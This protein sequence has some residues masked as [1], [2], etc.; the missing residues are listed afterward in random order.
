MRCARHEGHRLGPSQS[1]AAARALPSGCNGLRTALARRRRSRER[2]R[3]QHRRLGRQGNRCG[4]PHSGEVR[5]PEEPAVQRVRPGP[6]LPGAPPGEHWGPATRRGWGLGAEGH[7]HLLREGEQV[8]DQDSSEGHEGQGCLVLLGAP[9]PPLGHRSAHTHTVTRARA[10]TSTRRT[11][12]AG[13]APPATRHSIA[14]HR[15]GPW[16]WWRRRPKRY[17]RSACSSTTFLKCCWRCAPLGPAP[18]PPGRRVGG[19]SVAHVR[20]EREPSRP[21]WPAQSSLPRRA[22]DAHTQ[23]H[24]HRALPCEVQPPPPPSPRTA[25]SSFRSSRAPSA[26]AVSRPSLWS[27]SNPPSPLSSRTETIARMHLARLSVPQTT[28]QTAVGNVIDRPRMW[29]CSCHERVHGQPP[30]C[31][32]GFGLGL[33]GRSIWGLC[34]C[35]AAK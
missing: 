10:R 31:C 20:Q 14:P 22:I 28:R 26:P 7:H 11:G 13:H 5:P 23:R 18:T 6:V 16:S 21:R 17:K 4:R 29:I 30:C 15:A 32:V 12:H 8:W 27:W 19:V 9:S 25:S 34:F 1:Q 3:W 33:C 2:R 24:R 35:G